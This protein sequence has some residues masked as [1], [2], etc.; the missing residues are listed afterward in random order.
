MRHTGVKINKAHPVDLH[1]GRLIGEARRGAGLS[2]T[3][4]GAAAGVSCQQIEKYESGG[5]RVPC[6]VLTEIAAALGVAPA[7]FFTTLPEHVP[8]VARRA[9][10]YPADSPEARRETLDLVRA[11]RAIEDEKVRLHVRRLLAAVAPP[12]YA[13]AE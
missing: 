9:G 1:I 10:A 13:A 8:R 7:V 5:T 11:Y 12:I 4:L 6:S 2:Q 3:Q